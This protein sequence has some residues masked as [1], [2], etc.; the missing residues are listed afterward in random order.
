VQRITYDPAFVE[1][2]R[3]RLAV[4]TWIMGACLLLPLGLL[5]GFL[6]SVFLTAKLLP[7]IAALIALVALGRGSARR[8][9]QP[10]NRIPSGSLTAKSLR[11]R[12]RE[13]AIVAVL[14]AACLVVIL[15]QYLGLL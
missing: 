1:R 8:F 15:A 4:A 3:R 6:P 13:A 10:G 9:H 12:P 2:E 11:A 14:F 5:A 7:A